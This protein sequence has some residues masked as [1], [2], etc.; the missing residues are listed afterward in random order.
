M[1]AS[2]SRLLEN[3]LAVAEGSDP[4]Q[5]TP[6]HARRNRHALRQIQAVAPAVTAA[7]IER[8][9][10]IYARVMPAGAR[11]TAH[12]LAL[13]WAK[14]DA[15]RTAGPAPTAAPTGWR[16]RLEA[17]FPGNRINADRRGFEHI[18]AEIRRQLF[19][20]ETT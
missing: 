9:A 10:R 7:E 4:A 2:A 15:G 14:C 3:A 20:A 12:A 11:C 16:E 1:S 18:P 5:L 19:P 8:R 6:A 17:E 13:H